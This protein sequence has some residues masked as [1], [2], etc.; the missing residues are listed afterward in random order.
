ME[1]LKATSNGRQLLVRQY[2]KK[3][4]TR[5]NLKYYSPKDYR[6]AEKKYIRFCLASG[7]C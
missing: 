1:N 4:K 7:K 3:F 6:R 2:R 5:E